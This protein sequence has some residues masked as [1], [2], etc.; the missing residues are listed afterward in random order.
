M[1]MFDYVRCEAKLPKPE[2]MDDDGRFQT[3]DTNCLL[4]EYKI[5]ADGTLWVQRFD[6]ET[7]EL[8]YEECSDFHGWMNFYGHTRETGRWKEYRAKFTDGRMVDVKLVRD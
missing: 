5:E 4:D 6:P 8:W 3:K 1:G 2:P 7:S